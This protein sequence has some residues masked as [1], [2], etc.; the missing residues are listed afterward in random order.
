MAERMVD[1]IMRAGRK[2]HHKSAIRMIEETVYILR[3]APAALLSL[4]YTGSVPFVLGLLYFWADMSRSANAFKYNEVAALG[5]AFLYIWMKVWNTLFAY[6]VKAQIFGRLQ[7]PWSLR[8]IASIA[9]TQS[10]IQ[11]TRFLVIPIASLI[12]IPFGYCYAFY[13]NA[14]AHDAAEGQKLNSTCKWAW[15]QARLWPRQN[16]LLIGIY[17]LFGIAIFLNVS[18]TAV[19]LPQLIKTLFGVHSIFTLSGFHMIL[20]TTFWIAMLGITYL[21]LDPLIKTTYV[22]RCFYGSVLQSGDDLRLELKQ[23]AAAGIKM[24]GGLLIAIMC[25]SS[26]ASA[27]AQ[28]AG[29]GP[30][31]LDRSIE[32]TLK[33]R[34]F[35]WR[36]PREIIQPEEQASKGPLEAGVEWLVETIG[37]GMKKIG[38]WIRQLLDWLDSLLPQSNK[39]TDTAG[40]NWITP[41]RMLLIVLLALLL[42]ILTYVFVRILRRR[43]TGTV[44]AVSA[45]QVPT[46][47]LND[48][49][50][51]ADDLAA[52]NWLTLAGELA[53]KGQLRLAARALYLATLA[54]LAEHNMITIEAHKSNRE[55]ERELKRRAHEYQDLISIFSGCLNFFERIWYGMHQIARTDFDGYAA[56]HQRIMA[57]AEK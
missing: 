35:T 2:I 31:E 44:E 6:Q 5:L 22:L 30:T 48:E 36:M 40:G 56:D 18:M 9:A 19:F 33:K 29:L 43:R 34:E 45:A 37:K 53:E 13:Q 4:Y 25:L 49:S 8:R 11:S 51:T 27:A 26:F 46:P 23:I 54:K 12:M 16:H 21:F 14:A 52:N 15:Q 7:Y 1:G 3:S 57:F 20:N 32:E 41:V 28:P 10:L 24:T 17:W 55:Y 50:L 39:Q 47:D 38:Q 42:A